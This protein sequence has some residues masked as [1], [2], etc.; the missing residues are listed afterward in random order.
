MP[1]VFTKSKCALLVAEFGWAS[2]VTNDRP[3]ADNSGQLFQL[4]RMLAPFV[5]R[6][7]KR[8]VLDQLT[9]KKS[10][11]RKLPMTPFQRQIYENVLG[12]YACRKAERK[13]KF[14]AAAVMDDFLEGKLSKSKKREGRL[15]LEVRPGKIKSRDVIDLCDGE[16]EKDVNGDG[17][18]EEVEQMLKAMSNTEVNHLF[19][20]LRK[21][22]NHPLLLR[23]RYTDETVLDRI[24]MVTRVELCSREITS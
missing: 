9:E 18:V 8:D 21:A 7:L 2:R 12:G 19:T 24:A 16:N 23:I 10:I 22:A 15:A 13:A 5:L 17:D 1:S 20:A 6:R 4:K 14:Q 11:V 3:K